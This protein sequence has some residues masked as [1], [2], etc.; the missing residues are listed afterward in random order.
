[1]DPPSPP[2]FPPPPPEFALPFSVFIIGAVVAASAA[3]AF[4]ICQWLFCAFVLPSQNARIARMRKEQEERR[5]AEEERKEAKRRQLAEEEEL[6][7][8]APPPR[9]RTAAWVGS[10]EEAA[11][12]LPSKPAPNKPVSR[13]VHPTP[14]PSVVE[15]PRLEGYS[16]EIAQPVL[17]S[18]V[19]CSPF[20][21]LQ[22]LLGGGVGFGLAYGLFTLI[23]SGGGPYALISAETLVGLCCLPP[24]AAFFSPL[25]T[26]LAL[27]EAAARRW[28]GYVEPGALPLAFA[29]MPF[30]H[31]RSS[32]ARLLLLG[33]FASAV[34]IP[35]G[36]AIL[37]FA[38][39]APYTAND[40]I[41][42][43]SFYMLSVCVLVMPFGVL[44][45]CV[46]ANFERVLSMMSSEPNPCNRLISRLGNVLFC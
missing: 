23:L 39:E 5:L 40:L 37:G 17:V 15:T 30:L 26:P 43:F 42:F 21:L 16:K 4:F 24:L 35:A 25:F 33:I 22:T 13:R 20:V 9:V 31:A 6:T 41:L 45:L 27:P 1:M 12:A 29:C 18:A 8:V 36:F 14:P 2:S 32:V 19:L 38:L 44:G 34:W 3:C 11:A 10:L 46:E 7:Q 28:L